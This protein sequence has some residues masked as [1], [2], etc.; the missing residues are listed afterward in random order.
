MFQIRLSRTGEQISNVK[1]EQNWHA[2]KLGDEIRLYRFIVHLRHITKYAI[3]TYQNIGSSIR[4]LPFKAI[5]KKDDHFKKIILFKKPY[6]AQAFLSKS[7]V[8]K[9]FKHLVTLHI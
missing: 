3:K 2:T 4:N 7:Q 5:S 8:V 9:L 6:K 1:H